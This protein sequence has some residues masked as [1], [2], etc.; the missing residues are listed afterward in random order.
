MGN[1]YNYGTNTYTGM[2]FNGTLDENGKIGPCY[3]FVQRYLKIPGDIIGGLD[4][5]TISCWV[6]LTST[7]YQVFTFEYNA[8]WQFSLDRNYIRVR[9]SVTGITGTRKDLAITAIPQ[10]TWTHV[11][12]VYDKGDIFVYQNGTLMNTLRGNQ[13]ASM[14]TSVNM[15][16]V[17]AD[18]VNGA[19]TYPGNCKVND[20]R[21]YD[22]CLSPQ[23]VRELSRGLIVHYPLNSPE[24]TSSKYPNDVTW[25]QLIPNGDFSNGTNNW[26]IHDS[27]LEEISV[28]NGEILVTKKASSYGGMCRVSPFTG[29]TTHQYYLKATLKSN[30]GSTGAYFGFCTTSWTVG[31]N[32]QNGTSSSEYETISFITS[33]AANTSYLVLRI[34]AGSSPI[35]ASLTCKNIF[36]IDLTAMFGTGNE[37]T[38][39]ECDMLFYADYYPYDT[40]TT[41]N[42]LKNIQDC[43]GYNHNATPVNTVTL[44]DESP[45]YDKHAQFSTTSYIKCISPTAEVRSASFW[46][47]MTNVPTNTQ[48]SFVDYKSHLGFGT[49]QHG[50]ICMA[51][52]SDDLISYRKS[53]TTLTANVWHHIVVINPDNS[54]TSTNRVLYIDGVECPSITDATKT[55]LTHSVDELQIGRRTYSNNQIANDISDF[56]LYV[57]ALTQEDVLDLY[58]TSTMIDNLGSIHTFD[59]VEDNV[60]SQEIYDTGIFKTKNFIESNDN[61]LIDTDGSV[62]LKILHHNNPASNLFTQNNN[63]LNNDPDLFSNLIIL[64]DSPIFSQLSEYEFIGKEK[65]TTSSTEVT[66]RWKQTNNPALTSSATGFQLLAGSAA[67]LTNGLANAGTHGCFDISGDTWWCCCGAYD[68]YQGGIP[69]FTNIVTTGYTDL[70]IKIPDTLLKGYIDETAK[71]YTDSAYSKQFLEI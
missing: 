22:Y 24:I 15:L 23:E 26:V 71:F 52:N 2:E 17:G 69:G 30:N 40:G 70:Y 65:L 44:V 51:A 61:L 55:Y 8:Y 7:T 60:N 46:L 47:K 67:K 59:F 34:G 3:S 38:K 43:S 33:P 49:N 45:K 63:W 42:I 50:C 11:T 62:F 19:S 54:D 56:R 58:H 14:N 31:S 18:I 39:E 27:S 37:P 66:Y 29:D 32:T 48:V 53:K 57:T 36:C 68:A 6:Y 9:D 64:K 5:F 10:T 4:T 41:K 20:F 12:V 25:N 16:C 13:G 1:Y 21:V 28:S 35:G